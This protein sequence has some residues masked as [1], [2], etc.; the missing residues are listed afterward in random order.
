MTAPTPPDRLLRVRLARFLASTGAEDEAAR[1]AT[2]DDVF[3]H[4]C[5]LSR[6]AMEARHDAMRA[7]D[8]AVSAVLGLLRDWASEAR[9]NRP[10]R[11]TPIDDDYALD[12]IAN[13]LA[14]EGSELRRRAAELARVRALRGSR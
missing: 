9:E 4:V 8:D 1:H 6:A 5:D 3:D 13:A 12:A 7:A 10:S 14:C 2:D 11:S